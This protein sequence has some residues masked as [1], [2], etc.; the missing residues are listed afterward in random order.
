MNHFRDTNTFN[1]SRFHYFETQ[2]GHWD[3][4]VNLDVLR[5][6]LHEILSG[7]SI[8]GKECILDL[9]CG[10]GILTSVLINFMTEAGCIHAV[11]YSPAMLAVAKTKLPSPLIIWHEAGAASLPI[12]SG[13]I[14]LVLCFS[15]WAHF[16]D[17]ENV[18]RELYRV[19]KPGG[20]LHILHLQSRDRINQIHAN[21]GG[22]IAHDHLIPAQELADLLSSDGFNTERVIDRNELYLVS[23]RK[24]D[25][26]A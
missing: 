2:A 3:N 13:Q 14:D 5:P 23:A 8:T 18:I 9:G 4:S 7:L 10:T 12:E 17:Q 24:D 16:E 20:K 19:L 6:H 25:R 21:A 11:D 1:E 26:G 22:P 15:S